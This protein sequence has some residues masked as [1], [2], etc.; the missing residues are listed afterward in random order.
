L[1]SATCSAEAARFAASLGVCSDAWAKASSALPYLWISLAAV[2]VPTPGTP[3]RLSEGSPSSAFKS[4]YF[5]G[6][7][8]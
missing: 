3:G 5:S 1:F 8:P 6:G 7:M 2:F 4:M